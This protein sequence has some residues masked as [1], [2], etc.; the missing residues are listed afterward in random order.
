MK[1]LDEEIPL[2]ENLDYSLRRYTAWWLLL[3][4]TM[5]LDVV[6]TVGF[7]SA[8][9]LHKEANALARWLME[10]L[11]LLPGLTA[12]KV[13]QVFAVT[14]IVSLNRRVGNLFLMAIVLLN[15]WAVVINSI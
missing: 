12:A 2:R 13:L 14:A 6:S 9:G 4:A 8:L 5:I 10:A 11:G 15:A 7:V 1:I 3:L